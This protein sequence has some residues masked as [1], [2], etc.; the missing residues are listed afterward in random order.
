M[1]DA[2]ALLGVDTTWVY[3]FAS[4]DE[5]SGQH[6]TGEWLLRASKVRKLIDHIEQ[7]DRYFKQQRNC[8]TAR[9]VSAISHLVPTACAIVPNSFGYLFRAYRNADD[10][11]LLCTRVKGKTLLDLANEKNYP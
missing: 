2:C 7:A 1:E 5:S 6:H 9:L 3:S 10:C 11:L 4:S 8:A